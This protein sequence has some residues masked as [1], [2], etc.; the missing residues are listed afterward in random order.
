MKD[1]EQVERITAFLEKIG[2]E[3][4]FKKLDGSTF[5]PGIHVER[6]KIQIDKEKLLYPGDL[7][8]EAGH[9]A[10][11]TPDERMKTSGN[12]EPGENKQESM[13]MGVICWSW[14]A[15]VHLQLDPKVVFHDNG[16][17]GAS[18]YYINMYST[19]Q[20]IGL[21]LLQWAELCKHQTDPTD[22]PAF[23]HMLKWLRE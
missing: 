20:C 16:Y 22:L 6:G 3:L 14:A 19:G 2:L 9:L 21:P 7:L 13:E 11:L 23:P 18:N 5:L 4:E 10:L 8:H 15:L 1:T 17:R 12:I